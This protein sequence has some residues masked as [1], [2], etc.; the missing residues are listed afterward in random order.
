MY[1]RD[2]ATQVRYLRGQCGQALPEGQ[3]VGPGGRPGHRPP[4]RKVG[5]GDARRSGSTQTPWFSL[6]T[7]R[8]TV[9]R[10]RPN[11]RAIASAVNPAASAARIAESRSRRAAC[12]HWDCGARRSRSVSPP[13]IP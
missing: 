4:V 11:E 3:R 7:I 10:D 2:L 6:R 5:V 8:V 9:M 1:P 13:Q 12:T